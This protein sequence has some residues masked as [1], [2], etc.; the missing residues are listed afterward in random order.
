[1]TQLTNENDP[2][3]RLY[4]P[5]ACMEHM[6]TDYWVC[7]SNFAAALSNLSGPAGPVNI[8]PH[9]QDVFSVLQECEEFHFTRGVHLASAP[10][11]SH[12]C[13]EPKSCETTM[14][15]GEVSR[16]YGPSCK[17]WAPARSWES[18]TQ[19]FSSASSII[20]DSRSKRQAGRGLK[21]KDRNHPLESIAILQVQSEHDQILVQAAHSS[22]GHQA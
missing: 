8:D 12:V 15:H 14:V 17:T 11:V 7:N 1:M 5:D 6:Q 19:P 3:Y 18:S 21:T 20:D 2:D 4:I 22:R 9:P 16:Q 10:H 13:L